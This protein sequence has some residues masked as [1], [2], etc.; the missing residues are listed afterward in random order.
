M[1]LLRL[2]SV[3]TY[4]ANVPVLKGISLHVRPGELVSL[5]GGNG[6]GKTTTLKTISGLLRPR[7]GE[8]AFL[9]E[10]IT[11]LPPHKI[12][13]KGLSHVPEGR[14]LFV[15]MSVQSNLEMGGYLL[16]DREEVKT[17]VGYFE[18]LF[19]ILGDRRDQLAG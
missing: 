12:V 13:R 17:R 5:I 9:G 19:S 6:A 1:D 8:V 16:K 4:Y 7:R 11:G 2:K 3:H 10:N 15:K 14:Q 18:S